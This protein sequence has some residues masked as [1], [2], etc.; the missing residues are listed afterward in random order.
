MVLSGA[1]LVVVAELVFYG[2]LALLRSIQSWSVN[3]STML[4]GRK[5]EIKQTNNVPGQA[6]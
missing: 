3:L 4:K 6:S 2:P 5:T 1:G